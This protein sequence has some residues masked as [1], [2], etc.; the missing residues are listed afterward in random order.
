MKIFVVGGAGYI[1]SHCCKALAAEGFV[2]VTYDN[3]STGHRS[4]VRWGPLFEGDICD[5]DRLLAVLDEVQPDAVLHFAALALVGPSMKDPAS[6]YDTNVVGTLRLLQAMRDQ[7]VQHLVFS[8]TCAVY[9]QPEVIP[10]SESAACR[11]TNPYGATKLAC[12]SMMDDFN[13]AYGIRSVRLRYFNAAGA[14]PDGEIGE[15][16]DPETHLVPLVVETA[17]GRRE[18]IDVFGTDYPTRDGTAIRDYIHVSDLASAH[19]AALKH[20]LDGGETRAVN[21]GTGIGASVEEVIAQVEKISGRSVPRHLRPRR[22]G[23]PAQLIAD[24]TAAMSLL[25]WHATKDLPDIIRD[26]HSWHRGQNE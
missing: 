6:Y 24:P 19:V 2:P 15:R 17:L 21:L 10:I 12:E 13:R 26:A 22:E 14:D 16:H 8:S 5:R 23:D 25:G 18:Y 1:G 9:G 4:F 7:G 3:L 11:P 20:L